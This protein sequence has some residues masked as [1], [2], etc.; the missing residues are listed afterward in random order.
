MCAG[1]YVY[2]SICDICIRV[3]QNV[4]TNDV[5]NPISK[6]AY[7]STRAHVSSRVCLF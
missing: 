6:I 7:R 3:Y 5:Y 1:V 4:Q 2:Y